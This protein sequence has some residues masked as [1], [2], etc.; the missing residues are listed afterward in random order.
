MST[1]NKTTESGSTF[2]AA[3]K[4][5][6]K[7]AI[8]VT[9]I[10]TIFA[11]AGGNF[12]MGLFSPIS[13]NSDFQF[14]DLYCKV[15]NKL[16]DNPNSRNIT[17]I[18]TDSLIEREHLAEA[19]DFIGQFGP[20][21]L[22][23]DIH[24]AQPQDS[25]SDLMLIS[26]L[27]SCNCNLVFPNPLYQD[28]FGHIQE[29][30]KTFLSP[31]LSN[32]SYGATNY[33]INS[34]WGPTRKFETSFDGEFEA[35]PSFAS[36]IAR[37]VNEDQ[38]YAL[39]A[40][41]VKYERK[42]EYINYIVSQGFD[43]RVLT[44]QDISDPDKYADYEHLIKNRIVLLG[45]IYNPN[46]MHTTPYDKA[47]AGIYIHAHA[48]DTILQGA[49]YQEIP[50]ALLYIISIICCLLFT[51]FSLAL[52]ESHK[53]VS[54]LV[55]RITQAVLMLLIYWIGCELYLQQIY[56]DPVV[57]ILM[58]VAIPFTTDIYQGTK[59]LYHNIIR[60]LKKRLKEN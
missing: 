41:N 57:L 11:L 22:G 27:S 28:A 54:G 51:S 1:K 44:L 49:Y 36:E 7:V 4:S 40:R 12:I 60:E 29:D 13:G 18:A 3:Y 39:L 33:T 14:S 43:T 55:I 5:E 8:I 58:I 30:R 52:K 53:E 9:I 6:F 48:L 23:I 21:V 16:E 50:K 2:W 24:F 10:T 34:N 25:L 31:F 56:F 45:D 35:F 47:V 17:I 42:W 20:K 15:A 32:A 26:A 19:I 37:I 59:G 38:H 46:D